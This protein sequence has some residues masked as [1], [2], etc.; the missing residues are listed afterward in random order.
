MDLLKLT[1][2]VCF[3]SE[4]DPSS[5]A[6]IRDSCTFHHYCCDG[7]NDKVPL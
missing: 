7:V 2:K 5:T 3:S 1:S 4:V 6:T